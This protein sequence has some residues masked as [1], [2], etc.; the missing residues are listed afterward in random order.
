MGYSGRVILGVMSANREHDYRVRCTLDWLCLGQLFFRQSYRHAPDWPSPML[1]SLKS[2][3]LLLPF[4]SELQITQS[5]TS[6]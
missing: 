6:Y 1:F 4:I 3:L 2:N 5:L